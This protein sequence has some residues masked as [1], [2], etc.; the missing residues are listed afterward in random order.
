MPYTSPPTVADNQILTASYL[1]LLSNDIAFL[2]GLANAAAVPFNSF[3]EVHITLDQN[4]M[5][6]YVR[7]RVPYLHWKISSGGGNWNYCRVYFN[8]VLVGEGAVGATFTGTYNL[9]S[10]AGLP[11][12]LGAWA[13]GVA[14]ED[15]V[16]GGGS[17]GNGDD[18]HV[19]TVGGQ[20]YRC[21]LAHTSA[22]GNQPGSGASWTTYWDL[23]TLPGIGT[24]CTTWVDVNFTSGTLAR[25]EYLVETDSASF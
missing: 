4:S 15:D 22:A 21:K 1:N 3:G 23:L 20:Y 5:I 25:I 24:I 8:G 17:G 6:W 11:H 9:S 12:L 13:T 18:G 19:V 14:Y 7:H 2:Y 16:H 10:W